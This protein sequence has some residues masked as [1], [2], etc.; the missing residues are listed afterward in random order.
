MSDEFRISVIIPVYNG[1]KYLGEAINSILGQSYK[2]FEVIIIDDGSTDKTSEIATAYKKDLIYFFQDNAGIAASRNLGVNMA[3]GNYISFL[4]A[5]DL[6]IKEKLRIQ[7]KQLEADPSIDII[8]GAVKHFYSP[9]TDE[10]FKKSVKCPSEL[11]SGLLPGTMLIKK[12]TFLSV[13][14]FSNDYK[15]G[16]FIEWYMKAKEKN[17]KIYYMPEI[18]LKRRIHGSN[19]TLVNKHIKNDYARIVRDMLLRRKEKAN[20]KQ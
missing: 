19:Y 9:D 17:L 7:K 11:S 6:W 10:K 13:G 1:E 4:D 8:F 18:L 5:D 14:F 2:P 15:V 16:E 3:K 20:G 12:R